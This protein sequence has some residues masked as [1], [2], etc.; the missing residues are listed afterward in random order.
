MQL[1]WQ[2]ISGKWY[3]FGT[4]DNMRVGWQKLSGKWY[5]FDSEGRMVTGKRTISRGEYIFNRNG[6]MI[7]DA[8]YYNIYKPFLNDVNNSILRARRSDWSDTFINIEVPPYRL[9]QK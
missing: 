8:K 1:G 2:K 3:Y 5:Y 4:N 6:F 7:Q 9:G